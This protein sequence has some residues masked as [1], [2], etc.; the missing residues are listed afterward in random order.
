[1]SVTLLGFLKDLGCAA[2]F[3]IAAPMPDVRIPNV[4]LATLKRALG[5]SLQCKHF[6][7]INSLRD[8]LRAPS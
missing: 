6:L 8:Y 2:P 5:F 7:Y 3:S 1:M 4:G